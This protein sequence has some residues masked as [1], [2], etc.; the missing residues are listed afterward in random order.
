MPTEQV[1][2][3]LDL[4]LVIAIAALVLSALSPLISALISGLFQI[5]EKT[6]EISAKQ[7][8]QERDFYYRHRAEVIERYIST[9]GQA[10]LS[11]RYYDF[12]NSMGEIYFY[13]DE[14]LWP[15]LDNIAECFHNDKWFMAKGDFIK[16]CKELS[17][18]EI[19]TQ[20]KEQPQHTDTHQPKE[21]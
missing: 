20:N 8:E 14:S 7:R 1:S 6:L 2:T 19:R 17:S 10:I 12:G 4:S 16:L 21:I 5:K 13:V 18:T 9:A 15:L 11:G 3:G